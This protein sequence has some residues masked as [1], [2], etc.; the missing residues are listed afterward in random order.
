VISVLSNLLPRETS[1]MTHAVL[2]GRP[3]AALD[4]HRRYFPL[5]RALFVETNPVPV[6]AALGLL[7]RCDPFVRPPLAALEEGNLAKLKA[8]MKACGLDG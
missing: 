4:L 5:M 2:E 7:G 3:S 1:Q 8:A 6:K